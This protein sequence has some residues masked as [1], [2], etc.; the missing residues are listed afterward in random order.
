MSPPIPRLRLSPL[1]GSAPTSL[2]PPSSSPH[3]ADRFLARWID[4]QNPSL[5]LHQSLERGE[6][7]TLREAYDR[8]PIAS[9]EALENSLGRT[10]TA[11]LLSI[12]TERDKT[13]FGE[14]LLNLAS[15]QER[16]GREDLAN[17][18]YSSIPEL[19]NGRPPTAELLSVI[20]RAEQRLSVLQGGGTFGN[21]AEHWLKNLTVDST[22]QSI[23][24]A[25]AVFGLATIACSYIRPLRPLAAAGVHF[26]S[27]PTISATLLA[28]GA[29]VLTQHAPEAWAATGRLWHGGD[30]NHS[31]VGDLLTVSGFA[32][33]VLGTGVGVASFG[34]GAQTFR[35][36]RGA[37]LAEGYTP[38]AATRVAMFHGDAV[39]RA[40]HD[41]EIWVQFARS[42]PALGAWQRT[43]LARAGIFTDR[44]LLY[45][46]AAVGAGRF[47]Y[48][49]HQYAEGNS[50]GTQ[51]PMS[52]S[53]LLLG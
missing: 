37:A 5:G 19:R 32:L 11:E 50:Q 15:R 33:G 27:K 43:W 45:G 21:R 9:R 2:N 22:T 8:L 30:A 53:S 6:A 18:L 44:S 52:M 42:N 35:N 1:L 39:R 48:G 20:S 28:S 13:L 7:G 23:N 3:P 24:H 47:A 41:P 46:S 49:L 12:S 14:A 17:N 10:F 16:V 38:A 26:L 29:Y 40:V 34:L 36:V 51:P 25:G 31:G 4:R